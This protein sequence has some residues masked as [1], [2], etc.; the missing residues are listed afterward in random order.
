M[1]LLA[2][3]RSD[4][5]LERDRSARTTTISQEAVTDSIPA[6]FNLLNASTVT[7]PL[8][9]RSHHSVADCLTSQDEIEEMATRP[10][11]ELV[12]AFTLLALGAHPDIAFATSS[13]AR[14]E[15]NP[16]RVHWEAAK[17]VLRYLMGTKKRC[18]KLGGKYPESLPSRMLT[19][20][21]SR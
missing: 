18:F 7:M 1:V 17:R 6:R 3:E 2:R 12:G 14:L 19:W 4:R 20:E 21:Q 5:S 15:H 9:P 16:G 11:R 13:L 10:Y 8:A